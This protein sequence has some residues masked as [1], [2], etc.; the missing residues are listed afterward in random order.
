MDPYPGDAE[1]RVDRRTVLAGLAAGGLTATSGCVRQT[2]SVVNRDGAEQLSLTITTVPSDVDRESIRI[3]RILRNNLEAVGIDVTIDML[4]VEEFYRETLVNH[5]FDCYVGPYHGDMDP[6]LLYELLYSAFADEPGWQNPFGFTSL[7]FDELLEDLHESPDEDRPEHVADVLDVLADEQPF[8]PLCVPEELRLVR[9][10]RFE[11]W[12]DHHLATRLGYL[13]LEPLGPDDADPPNELR[14]VV[15]DPRPTENLNPLSV[16]YRERGTYVDLLYDSLGTADNDGDEGESGDI[17]PW[18]AESWEWEDRTGAESTTDVTVT[19]RPEASFH[20]GEPLTADDVAFTYRFVEDTSLGE[21]PVAAPSPR[22]RGKVAAVESVEALDDRTLEMSIETGR[23][24]GERA[25]TVPILPEHIWAERTDEASVFG[26]ARRPGATDA[27]VLDNVPPIGSGPYQFVDRSER[28]RLHLE[29]FDEHF[30]L[31]VDGLPQPTVE[32]FTTR[33][34]PRSASAIEIV[35]ENDADVTVSPLES[36]SIEMVSETESV[37]LHRS[38]SQTFYHVGFNLRQAPFT[39]PYFRQVF[40]RLLDKAHLVEEVF[41]GYARPVATPLGDDEAWVPEAY[42]W[43][44]ETGTGSEGEDEGE[45]E[46]DDP[47]A[48]FLGSAGDVDVSRARRAFEEAG[49]RYDDRGSL[50]VRQ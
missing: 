11:G 4:A 39:S 27:V 12:D 41:E 2:R 19:L 22:Y 21:G 9:T 33:V 50:L 17:Y 31:G 5:D 10:D 35:E 1:R 37:R 7:T 30:S 18:L 46:A 8:V 36:Y 49:Y 32:R 48:P 34:A 47:S 15:T 26:F 24:A 6:E 38:P 13:G 44:G 42:R 3:A 29:R 23:Q 20:D 14:G 40:A 45:G 43:G 25:L 16:E 28:E